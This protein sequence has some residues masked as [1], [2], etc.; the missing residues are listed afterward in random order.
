MAKSNNVDNI[1][2]DL[3]DQLT[4]DLNA[5]VRTTLVGLSREEDPISPIDTGFF[6]SSWTVGRTRPRP[7]DKREDFN[8]WKNIKAT[9]KGNKSPQAKV[10]PRFIDK[11]KYNFKIYEKIYIGNTAK[12]A[13]YALASP[14]QKIN[15]F[16]QSDLKNTINQIFK[17]KKSKVLLGS[18]SVQGGRGIGQFADPNRSFV[19]YENVSDIANQ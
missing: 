7:K 15:L 2:P 18:E 6:A 3:E 9:R 17:D 13:A 19:G 12:Y 5:F 11:I 14:R 1:A 4:K 10:E 16:I 8:P